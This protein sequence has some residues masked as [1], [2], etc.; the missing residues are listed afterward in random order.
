MTYEVT[1]LRT[2]MKG[3]TTTICEIPV[4]ERFFLAPT[5]GLGNGYV[6]FGSVFPTAN[7][8]TRPAQSFEEVKAFVDFWIDDYK[9][10]HNGDFVH[11]ST[12]V[13]TIVIYSDLL[14][15]S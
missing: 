6:L 15:R 12:D 1:K 8:G 13:R 7:G 11:G 2:R 10:L 14:P 3:L 5:V 4:A 9:W